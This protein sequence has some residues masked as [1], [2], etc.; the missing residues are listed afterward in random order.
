LG[1]KDVGLITGPEVLAA[2]AKIEARGAI[3]SAHRIKNYAVGI[4][5]YALAKGLRAPDRGNP[6]ERLN[7]ALS[8]PPPVKHRAALKA[9]DLPEF[10]GRLSSYDGEEL[11]QL[12]LRL[13]LYTFVRTTEMRF[14]RKVQFEG[15]GQADSLWRIP[16]EQ[17]KMD[18]EHLVPLA[19]Q[20]ERLVERIFELTKGS[21]F[22]FPGDQRNEV[23]SE[24]TM[25]FAL[26][27]MGY[28]GRAT[29]HGFRATASTILNENGFNSDW[30]ERQLAHVERDEVRAAYNAAEYLPQRR[31]MMCWWADYLDEQADLGNLIG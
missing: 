7:K 22:L 8:T 27:R 30:I 4:F 24:N 23:M 31:Q 17:M 12:A 19:P 16:P 25:L 1:P 21:E 10:F 18:N 29:V 3:E 13:T 5:E 26:Y 15:I 9:R 28:H 11:T 6:A 20:A 14:A 2:L